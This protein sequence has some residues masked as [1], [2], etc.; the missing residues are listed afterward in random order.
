MKYGFV[1]IWFDRKHKRF[2]IGSH[3]GFEN[4]GYICSSRW[5]R[6]AYKRRSNDFKRRILSLVF[7]S[8]KDLIEEEIYWHSFIKSHE[9]GKRYYNLKKASSLWHTDEY[10]RLTVSE[11]ISQKAKER[12]FIRNNSHWVK[13]Q[14]GSPNTEFKPGSIPSNKNKSLEDQFGQEKALEIKNKM[15]LKKIGKSPANKDQKGKYITIHNGFES[16][17]HDKSI[18]I[19]EGWFRGNHDK[20]KYKYITPW[21]EYY[22]IRE[23]LDKAAIKIG[24]KAL[25]NMCTRNKPIEKHN[26]LNIPVGTHPKDMGYGIEVI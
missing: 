16:K 11:K 6:K 4:D 2:Y 25:T 3:W 22:S 8:R 21:G 26:S 10:S 5:M 14:R 13:G 9:M 23:A 24:R 20:I 1:Y 18:P 7:T 12:G 17:Y 15:S 19:P